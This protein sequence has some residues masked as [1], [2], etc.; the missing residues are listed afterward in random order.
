M[1]EP[2]PQILT[3]PQILEQID[4]WEGLA[5]AAREALGIIREANAEAE[6]AM[7]MAERLTAAGIRWPLPKKFGRG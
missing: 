6:K 4:A 5:A 1:P 3:T 2:T 7:A